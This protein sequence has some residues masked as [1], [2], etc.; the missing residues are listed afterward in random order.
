MVVSTTGHV[1]LTLVCRDT[2]V[3]HAHHLAQLRCPHCH[4]QLTHHHGD[5]RHGEVICTQQHGFAIRHGVLDL[6]TLPPAQSRAAQSNE[7]QLTAWAYE[8]IWRPYAL[9]ILS[10]QVFGYDHELP[11]ICAGIATAQVIVDVACSNGLYARAAAR[12]APQA[13][14]IGID[15]AWPMLVE[16]E[17]RAHAAH[18]D[19]GY[20]CADARAL[21]MPDAGCDAI[22][23]GGSW[24][25][26]EETHRVI[27]EMS[28]ISRPGT[29]LRSMGLTASLR[30]P[31]RVIQPLLAT[32]GGVHFPAAQ[33]LATTMATHGWH[34]DRQQ[35]YGIVEF[36]WGSYL[37]HD[38]D[39]A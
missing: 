34:I 8:R 36:V 19:I 38:R 11:L 3:I 23:I 14:V 28:R 2:S 35:H 25:E 31:A 26:M 27:A 13:V 30:W 16:A 18:L 1:A 6:R 7:W 33:E 15:R 4:G 9:T 17:R 10:G 29:Q 37:P 21:P 20:V 12:T 24:N 32:H 39:N 5:A 22:L